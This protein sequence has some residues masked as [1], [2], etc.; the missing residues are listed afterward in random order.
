MRYNLNTFLA[1]L[2]LYTR[3]VINNKARLFVSLPGLIRPAA[4]K[5]E[6]ECRTINFM[7]SDDL[8]IEISEFPAL[9]R[10]RIR[11]IVYY[12]LKARYQDSLE[13]LGH[14]FIIL[15]RDTEEKKSRVALFLYNKKSVAIPG[16]E[17]PAVIEH[18]FDIIPYILYAVKLQTG[19]AA[20]FV[21][22][23]NDRSLIMTKDKG[24]F[25][26]IKY[27]RGPADLKS[28]GPEV[29]TNIKGL[30]PNSRSKVRFI[31]DEDVV[32][33]AYLRLRHE[34]I[35]EKKPGHPGGQVL[36]FRK[37]VST[38]S[39]LL[40]LLIITGLFTAGIVRNK[41]EVLKQAMKKEEGLLARAEKVRDEVNRLEIKKELL[42]GQST[43]FYYLFHLTKAAGN[44]VRFI[45]LEFSS[46]K[47]DLVLDAY[48]ENFSQARQFIQGLKGSGLFRDV[49][50]ESTE[51]YAANNNNFL[52]FR[53]SLKIKE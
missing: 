50:L 14:F 30:K 51:Q 20:L 33:R 41:H 39:L 49:S 43:W 8:K 45:S 38:G 6:L 46:L 34:T 35:E 40:I 27:I 26:S 23:S 22:R 10:S 24:I 12:D 17:G 31:P 5:P 1:D 32:Y 13:K 15:S 53:V 19:P 42:E 44:K 29:I 36:L 9:D 16:P 28:Q 52:K 48:S 37:L 47:S 3:L 18:C 21:I 2:G 4:D 11:K 25:T 7:P